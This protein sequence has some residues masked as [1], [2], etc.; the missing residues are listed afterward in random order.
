MTIG[1]VNGVYQYTSSNQVQFFNGTIS[2][3]KLNYLMQQYGITQ[4][5]NSYTD[6]KALYSA[7]HGYFSQYGA[8]DPSQGSNQPSQA[9]IPWAG[10]MNNIGLQVTGQ[11]DKDYSSFKNTV[12]FLTANA[13]TPNEKAIMQ[14]L[15]MQAQS[16]FIAPR[17]QENDRPTLS[18]AD[19]LAQMNKAF[20]SA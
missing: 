4:T 17:T 13:K 14:Q 15:S 6:M 11:I 20:I 16:V 7:M 2:N 12:D 5:G 1:A 10:L 3:D 19:I 8:I 9:Q 18:G